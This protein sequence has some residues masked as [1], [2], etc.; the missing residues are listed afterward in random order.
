ME[1]LGIEPANIDR[2][3]LSHAHGDHTGGLTG[4]LAMGIRPI[5]HVPR[6]F[7]LD[8]KSQVEAAAELVE[9]HQATKIAE[10]VYTTGEMG[11][12]VIEQALVVSTAKGLVVVTGCAHPGVVEMVERAKEMGGDEIYLVLGGFHLGGASEGRIKEII[13]EFQRLGV[14]KLAPCHCTGDKAISL[15]REAYGEDFIQN[16]AGQIIEVAP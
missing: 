10:G 13:G 6:S 4:L 14:R 15:F 12:G 5:V 7:P 3:V 1:R 2:V 9:V 11:S 8:F 16:G